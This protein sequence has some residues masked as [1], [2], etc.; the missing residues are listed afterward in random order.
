MG[1]TCERVGYALRAAAPRAA[2]GLALVLALVSAAGP[3]HALDISNDAGGVLIRYAL[4]TAKL[5]KSAEIVRI[6]G[7]CDSA[8]TLYLSLK[9]IC[10]T[11]EASFGFH[12]PI[13]EDS[14]ATRIARQYMMRN[15]PAWVRSWLQA[16]GGLNDDVKRMPYEVARRHLPACTTEPESL[17]THDTR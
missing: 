6:A 16:R 8:C 3:S 9:E 7:R 13:A 17:T 1:A 4:K 15:Y 10:I 5:R 11:P 12:A 14:E 2:L